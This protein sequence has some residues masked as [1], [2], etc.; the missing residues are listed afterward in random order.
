MGYTVKW[1]TYKFYEIFGMFS[2]VFTAETVTLFFVNYGN[3]FIYSRENVD[4]EKA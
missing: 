3:Y 4:E 1:T 2:T